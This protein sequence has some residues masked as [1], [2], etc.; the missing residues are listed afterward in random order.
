MYEAVFFIL[1]IVNAC[2]P[3]MEILLMM[4]MCSNTSSSVLHRAAVDQV[5]L[6]LKKYSVFTAYCTLI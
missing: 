3:T 4:G 2:M 5:M 6:L 1:I